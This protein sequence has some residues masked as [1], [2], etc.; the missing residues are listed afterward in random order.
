VKKGFDSAFGDFPAEGVIAH[1]FN[2]GILEDGKRLTTKIKTKDF[3]LP[4]VY[5]KQTNQKE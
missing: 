4:V 5:K 2:D 3:S 1:R